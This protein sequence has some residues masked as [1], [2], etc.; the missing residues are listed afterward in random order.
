M[1]RLQAVE[2]ST[3]PRAGI[4]IEELEKLLAK[5]PGVK[6]LILMPNVHNP[7]GN[8]MMA[9]G[10]LKAFGLTEQQLVVPAKK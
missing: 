8:I 2:V 10:V 6:A 3:D 5:N 1:L 9:N 7:L 4:S